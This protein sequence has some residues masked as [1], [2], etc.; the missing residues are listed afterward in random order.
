M[1]LTPVADDVD[2][3]IAFEFLPI[4]IS[5]LSHAETRFRIVSVH[6]KHRGLN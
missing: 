3:H 2:N 5:D 4:G 1:P 6:M